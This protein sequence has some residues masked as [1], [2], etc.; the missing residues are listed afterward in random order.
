M[1]VKPDQ[2]NMVMYLCQT[3]GSNWKSIRFEKVE[4]QKSRSNRAKIILFNAIISSFK[5]TVIKC[6]YYEIV[7]SSFRPPSVY[8]FK[9]F[10]KHNRFLGCD[11]RK[12]RSFSRI[13]K[14][15]NLR[16]W[17]LCIFYIT[18]TSI[19]LTLSF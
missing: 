8:F 16:E 2:M 1:G 17:F 7:E 5:I 11:Y 6:I 3:S 15:V 10:D 9:K 13:S 12:S 14:V 19:Y 18:I 4:L